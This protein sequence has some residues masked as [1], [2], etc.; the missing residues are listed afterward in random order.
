MVYG[1]GW[2][3]TNLTG[4]AEQGFLVVRAS[5]LEAGGLHA[6]DRGGLCQFAKQTMRPR[7]LPRV[8]EASGQQT[9][10]APRHPTDAAPL[11]VRL[12]APDR[13]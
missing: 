7:K 1:T 13:R 3:G 4:L 8:H 5:T 6:D 9:L 12:S 11:C 2:K 10:C